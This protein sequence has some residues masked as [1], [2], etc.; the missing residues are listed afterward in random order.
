MDINK[1]NNN[2]NNIIVPKQIRVKNNNRQ[3]ARPKATVNLKE[4]PNKEIQRR[5]RKL[6]K[7]IE[8]DEKEIDWWDMAKKLGSHAFSTLAPMAVKFLTGFGDYELHTN[9]IVAEA[10]G[11]ESGGIPLMENS[12]SANIIRHREYIGDI[13]GSSTSFASQTFD[14]NAGIDTTFPWLSPIAHNYTAYRFRGLVFEYVPLYAD[15]STTSYLGYVAM[16][17]QYNSLEKPYDDKRAMNNS[18]YSTTCKPSKSMMHPIE[19][20]AN[21]IPLSELYVRSLNP[22]SEGDLRMYDL[23]RLTVATGGQNSSTTIVGELWATYEIELY[24]PKFAGNM[25]H[26]TDY[27]KY[28]SSTVTSGQPLMDA[29]ASGLQTLNTTITNSDTIN[30]PH[31]IGAGCYLLNLYYRAASAASFTLGLF[32]TTNC[33]LLSNY[34]YGNLTNIPLTGTLGTNDYITVGTVI[35]ITAVGAKVQFA[36]WTLPAAT[37]MNLIITQIP[38]VSFKEELKL[39]K[40]NAWDKQIDD[41]SISKI[42]NETKEDDETSHDLIQECKIVQEKINK[43]LLRS[44][45]SNN[46]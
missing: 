25:S 10:T 13:F 28:T 35:N 5:R 7:D 4:N 27:V 33:A 46:K 29:T 12:K 23:G 40:P 15:Y 22:P 6:K 9:S 14:I 36:A 16:A 42:I 17:T 3:R 24:Q 19:C 1:N 31:N 21:Q 30:F 38:D 26:S 37:T 44:S 18:E 8:K 11:G 41:R 34:Y 32:N 39:V 45:S 2:K 43:L 20:A